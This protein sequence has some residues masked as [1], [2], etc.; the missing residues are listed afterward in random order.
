[1]GDKP[2]YAYEFDS[3]RNKF[4]TS[5]NEESIFRISPFSLKER[6]DGGE[7]SGDFFFF[8]ML[9]MEKHLTDNLGLN[10]PGGNGNTCFSDP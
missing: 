1:M 2:K 4:L 10:I 7:V 5:Q 6:W 9:S 8:L 3:K